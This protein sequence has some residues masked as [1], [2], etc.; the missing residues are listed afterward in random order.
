[1]EDELMTASSNKFSTLGQIFIVLF[2]VST[3]GFVIL[4]FSGSLVADTFVEISASV[5]P[6]VAPPAQ[7][8]PQG[9]FMVVIGT[10]LTSLTSLIGFITTTT[11]SWRKEKRE[12]A[13]AEMERKKLEL[14]LEKSKLEIEKLKEDKSK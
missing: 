2:I 10:V 1:M 12:A 8:V 5:D 4:A 9:G 3:L 14:D 7:S 11:I 6:N 13:L